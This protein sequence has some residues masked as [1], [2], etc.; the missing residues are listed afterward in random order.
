MKT[1]V[2]LRF[3]SR[4]APV[5]SATQV[6]GFSAIE[7]G[8][9]VAFRSTRSRLC[10]RAPPPVSMM[11]LS[12]ISA[13]SSGTVSSTAA[14][15]ASMMAPT[16]SAMLYATSRS[17]TTISFGKPLVRSRPLIVMLRPSPSGNQEDPPG[18]GALCRLLHRTP[19]DRCRTRGDAEH[20]LRAEKAETPADLAGEMPDHFT[21]NLKIGDDAIAHGSDRFD[22]VGRASQHQLGF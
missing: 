2:K 19:L 11:P 6:S 10:S 7:T 13:A 9:L 5:P 17:V 14:E 15:T 1:F 16:G 8:S 12:T 4:A 21:G 18:A 22:C 3:C 20:D